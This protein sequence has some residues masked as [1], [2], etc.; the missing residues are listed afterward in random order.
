MAAG[1][2]LLVGSPDS[3]TVIRIDVRSEGRP[4]LRSASR[5]LRMPC[6]RAG[7]CGNVGL[8]EQLRRHDPH[9]HQL[10]GRGT[11]VP[12]ATVSKAL[13]QIPGQGPFPR[14]ARVIAT[15]SVPPWPPETSA[16]AI[17]EG[18]VWSLQLQRRRLL[19]ID[20][21]TNRS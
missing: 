8:G 20:P 3:G 18:A 14:G 12:A 19:R 1:G 16:L 15:I 6:V 4:G 2:A 17:G 5:R 9:A 11:P 7:A 10:D 13:L 21:K